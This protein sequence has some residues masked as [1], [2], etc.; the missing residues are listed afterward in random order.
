MRDP[1]TPS[2]RSAAKSGTG[3]STEVGSRGSWPASTWSSSAASATL[4]VSG[5]TWSCD[6][7]SGRAPNLLTRPKVGLMPT[8]PQHAAGWRIEAPVSLPRAAKARPAATA[9]AEPPLEPPA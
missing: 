9:A 4:R 7:E 3:R 6:Q 2:L 8:M 1:W 5:P